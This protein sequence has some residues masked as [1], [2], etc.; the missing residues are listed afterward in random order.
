M[1]FAFFLYTFFPASLNTG[2]HIH[3]N[4][5]EYT[6]NDISRLTTLN[7]IQNLRDRLTTGS[8]ILIG[9]D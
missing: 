9:F 6:P 4:T 8:I 5:P 1:F 2:I 3:Q 7:W